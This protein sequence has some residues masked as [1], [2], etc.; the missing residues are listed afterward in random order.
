VTSSTVAEALAAGLARHQVT[1]IFGQ[2]LPS[3]LFLATPHYAIRQ[4]A[5]RTENAGGAMADGYAR[6]SGRIGVVAAQNGPAATLLVPP[7]A[8]AMKASVPVLA[9]VQEIPRANR[10]RNAFQEFDHEALFGSCAKWVRRLDDPARVDDYLDMAV[11]TACSGRPGPAVLLL[12]RDVLNVPIPPGVTGRR[13]RLGTFP[14][15]PTRP[16]AEPVAQAAEL[17]RTARRPVVVA[18]GGVHLSGAC[19][20][21]TRLQERASLPVGTTTMGKGAVDEQHPLS[22]GIVS[23]YMGRGSTSRHLRPVVQEADVVLL[24]GTR[25]NENG[26]DA[27][28][29]FPPGATYVHIDVDAAE[30]GRN[31][32][33][34]RLVGDA[35]L[36]LEDLC[37]ALE[38]G[39]L[40]ARRAA[41]DD[42]VERIAGAR[43]AADADLAPL[44][45]GEST[46]LRP[47]RVVAELD[48]ALRDHEVVLAADASYSTIWMGN[49]LRARR[50]GQRFLAPRGL[51]GLGWGVPL[52]LGARVARP[53]AVVVALVG[54]GG[55]GH[56]WSELETAVR[57]DLPI[58]VVLLN[59]GILGFQKH[60]ELVQFG[61]HTS[62]TDFASVDHAAVARACGADGVRVDTVADLGPALV[63]AVESGRPCLVEVLCDPDAYPPITAWDEAGERAI[64]GAGGAA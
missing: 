53:D 48:A 22:L 17:L 60:V 51:A 54:D 61:A 59:N 28:R 33:A 42:V 26:T 57:E 39:D 44:V 41:R 2:S 50:A 11:A 1:A 43:R 12:P 19:A 25:T 4:V 46:P 14:Q 38:A 29:A 16:A 63:K 13:A 15:D 5:Y 7:L 21:L 36:T 27:W 32:E 24:V 56:V 37:A 49:Q 18:G 58:V 55:F 8:E 10:D 52:A 62:A 35:R 3:A 30:V 23:N 6:V 45:A 20:A 31:Y 34:V 47:E 64:L 40:A 9:L